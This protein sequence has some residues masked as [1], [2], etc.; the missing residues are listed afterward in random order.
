MEIMPIPSRPRDQI[1]FAWKLS[2]LTF[3]S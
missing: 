1:L 2:D 3:F